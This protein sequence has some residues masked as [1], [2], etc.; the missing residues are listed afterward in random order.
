MPGLPRWSI[1]AVSSR[2]T[3]FP[4]IEVSGTAARH[5]RVTSSTMLRMRKRR[6]HARQIIA[7]W[8]HD[9]NGERPTLA[10]SG[11]PFIDVDIDEVIF[12]QIW[13]TGST[14]VVGWCDVS[15]NPA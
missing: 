2:A 4:E 3:R 12:A 8:V 11:Q 9:Y 10:Q 5:S 7:T 13:T 6:P 15:G 1:K 14:K